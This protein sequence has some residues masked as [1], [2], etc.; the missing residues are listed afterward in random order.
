MNKLRFFVALWISK[1][2][3][4]LLKRAGRHGSSF[5]GKLALRLCPDFA[6]NMRLPAVKIAITGTNGKTTVSN[7]LA[8][9][10]EKEGHSVL[11]NRYGSNMKSGICS[12]YIESRRW[13]GKD[14]A[15]DIAVLEVDE[16]SAE[17]IFPWL[18]P[19]YIVVTNIEN[20]SI[21]R[22]A[23]PEY[24]TEILQKNI[25]AEAVLILNADNP[26]SMKFAGQNKCIYFSADTMPSAPVRQ[27]TSGCRGAH[28]PIIDFRAQIS[29]SNDEMVRIVE[30]EREYIYPRINDNIVVIYD[31]LM[32]VAVLRRLGFRHE[33]ICAHMKPS[34]IPAS[35]YS[36]AQ[37]GDRRIVLQMAKGRNPPATTLAFRYVAGC[38]GCK[39]LLLMMSYSEDSKNGSE[40]V[41][42][43][44]GAGL[45]ALRDESI[46]QI[47]CTGA[48]R[49][50]LKLALMLSGVPEK[51]IFCESDDF[52][53]AEK[54]A[55]EP[56][57]DIYL[58]YGADMNQE[59]NKL[60]HYLK[61]LAAAHDGEREISA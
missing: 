39:E 25:P 56:G 43:L 22:N 45:G 44:Y 47:I 26:Y 53:A 20:D 14:S 42:W 1:L 51:K 21:M 24:I 50:D 59:E 11:C 13:F 7:M 6:L 17:H 31:M 10:L 60:F 55:F 23:H 54:L 3:L 34:L 41:A 18:R 57:D 48:R 4:L 49:M 2:A 58:L 52:K 28:F 40:N 12:A 19:D 61:E 33:T 37:M 9:I 30:G 8:S 46:V 38:G 15:C 29:P 36:E 5:P 16:R 35:R 27:D 32:V